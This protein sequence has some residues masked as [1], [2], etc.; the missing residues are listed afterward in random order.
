MEKEIATQEEIKTQLREEFFNKH[1]KKKKNVEVKK[2]KRRH[3]LGFTHRRM[4]DSS[5]GLCSKCAGCGDE[6]QK[7]EG[8]L[9]YVFYSKKTSLYPKIN[10]FHCRLNCLKIL[11]TEERRKFCGKKWPQKEIGNLAQELNSQA[12]Q[13]STE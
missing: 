6:I 9:E 4:V 12:S 10:K 3:K 8:R 2:R 7:E 13:L 5:K 1:E 11:N